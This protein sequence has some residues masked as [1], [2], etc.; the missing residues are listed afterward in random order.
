MSALLAGIACAASL[1]VPAL[2]SVQAQAVDDEEIPGRP[3]RYA[4]G[5]SRS[6]DATRS[7]APAVHRFARIFGGVGVGGSLRL[8]YDPDS[9]SQDLGGPLYLQA[10][11]AYFLEGEGDFQHGV[12]L[13]LATNLTIDPPNPDVANGFYELGQ[14]TLAP[15]YMLRF[16]VDDALQV[17]GSFGVPLALSMLYQSIGLEVGGGVVYKFLAGFGVFAHATFSLY[18]ASFVQPLLSFDAGVALDYEILP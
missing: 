1:V 8:V 4:W 7:D 18:F 14:W 11:V 16:W 2:G 17:M 5:E 13:G 12:G 10:R 15:S 3:R 9:L 6:A